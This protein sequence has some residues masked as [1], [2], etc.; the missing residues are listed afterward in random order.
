MSASAAQSLYSRDVLQLATSLPYDDQID[1]PDG[2]ATCRSPVCGSEICV[3]V[4]ID[5]GRIAALAI[6]ARAC[7]LG[8]ASAAMLR[9]TAIGQT[10]GDIENA[11]VQL[12][13]ALN[14]EG[15]MPWP[16]LELFAYAR[17]YPARHSAILLP[18]VTL[19]AAMKEAE[20]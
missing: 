18:F 8:Q 5:N 19:I 15:N 17:N 11:M 10:A 1:Q 16:E 20:R 4:A 2:R 13:A 3:D 12:Q 6:R 7:A 9:A 14:G